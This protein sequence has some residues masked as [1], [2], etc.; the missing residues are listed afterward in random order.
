MKQK[1][2]PVG[3]QDASDVFSLNSEERADFLQHLGVKNATPPLAH[4][5]CLKNKKTGLILPWNP[6]LAEQRDILECC[7][8]TGNTDPA[9]WQDKVQDDSP[10]DDSRDLMATALTE[11]TSKQN[12]IALEN[13]SS[14]RPTLRQ[15]GQPVQSDQYGNDAVPYS[16]IDN[17]L[18]KAE[19]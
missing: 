4:S 8:E 5:P 16:D 2:T 7:D 18:S 9:A 13:M 3:S 12:S 6:M 11:A 1:A 10:D 17:L 15:S 14:F 19:F